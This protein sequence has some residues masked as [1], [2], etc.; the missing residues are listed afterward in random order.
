LKK[1]KGY[2]PNILTRKGPTIHQIID[3]FSSR[4]DFQTPML[5]SSVHTQANR[6]RPLFNLTHAPYSS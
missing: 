2:R 6:Y 4:S 1:A 3:H 5:P